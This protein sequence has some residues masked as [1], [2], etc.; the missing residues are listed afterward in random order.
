MR[1]TLWLIMAISALAQVF[2]HSQDANPPPKQAAPP[3]SFSPAVADVVKLAQSGVGD[4]VVIAFIKNSQV[5]YN[6]SANEIRA[7]KNAGFSSQIMAAMLNH[8]QSPRNQSP[9]PVY[10][11][12]PYPPTNQATPAPVTPAS[13][14]V[15]VPNAP[16]VPNPPTIPSGAT[17]TPSTS[18]QPNSSTVVQHAPP[19][20]PVEVISASPGSNYYWVPGYWYWNGSW[21]WTGGRWVLRPWPGAVWVSGHWSKHGH[22]YIWVNGYWRGYES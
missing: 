1:R 19:A 4:D 18:P 20:T 14:P 21:V 12:K 8:D 3:S 11:Q 15:E 13:P 9:A 6:L 2:A 22:R 10:Q 16:T 17:N 5:P 7:L